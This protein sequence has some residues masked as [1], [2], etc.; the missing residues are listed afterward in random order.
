M[1]LFHFLDDV[2]IKRRV[3]QRRDVIVELSQVAVYF[4]TAHFSEYFLQKCFHG[5]D[6]VWVERKLNF[7]E[8]DC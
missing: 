1:I 5:S 3:S 6:A 8:K 2:S 4:V 7:A